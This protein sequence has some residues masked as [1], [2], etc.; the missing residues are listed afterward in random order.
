MRKLSIMIFCWVAGLMSIFA[1]INISGTVLDAD[2]GQPI[3]GAT[4]IVKNTTKG[5]ITDNNGNFVISVPSTNT[6]LRFSYI[7][8]EAIEAPAKAGMTIRLTT[9]AKELDEV[10]VTALGMTREKKSLGYSV[11]EIQGESLEKV[12]ELNVINS[13]AGREPGLIISQTAGGPTGSSRVEIRGSSMLT[14]NNQPLYVVDGVPIDNSNFGSASKDGG[15][16]LGDGISSIN[17]DDIE[18]ISVLKG[19]AASALYGS[20]AGNGVIM[21]TTKKAKSSRGS[22]GVELNSTTTVE[23]QLTKYNNVQYLYGQGTSGRISGTSDDRSNSAKSWGPRIDDGLNIWYFDNQLRP[24][25]ISNTGIDD[26]FRLGVT[27]NNT[28]TINKTKEDTGLRISYSDLRN[29]DIVP[30]SGMSRNTFSIRGNTKVGNKIDIDVKANYINENVKNRPALAGDRNNVGKNLITLPSTYDINLLK[31]NYKTDEGNYFN[32]NNDVNRVNPYWTINEMSN[33]SFKSR[34]LSTALISYAITKKLKLKATGG[35]DFSTFTFVDFAPRTT[36]GKETGYL[37]TQDNTNRTLN[38]DIQ[39]TYKTNF[40]K[41]YSVLGSVGASMLKT[42]NFQTTITGKDMSE[43]TIKTI[44]SFSEKTI[45]ESPYQRQINSAYGMVNLGYKNLV[46]LDATLRVD[47]TTT[48]INN[49]YLYPSISGSFI[50]SELFPASFKPV[51]SFAKLRGSWAE[52]GSDTSPYLMR[53]DY[54][55]YPNSINGL[56]MGGVAGSTIPNPDLKPT[57]TRSWEAGTELSFIGKRILLDLT[58]YDQ[59]SRDQI[60]RVNTSIGTGFSTAIL[61]SGVLNNKG[62]EIK[63]NTIPIQTKDLTWNLGVNFARNSNRVTALGDAQMYEIENAEWVGTAGVRVM[64]V[65]GQ[66][67]GTI[68]GKDYQR[69]ERGQIIVDG[70]TGLPTV[71]DFYTILGN[72]HWDWTGGMFTNLSYKNWTVNAILDVKVG[73]DMYSQTMRS[74]FSSG[75]AK[76]TLAGRDEWYQSEEQ[77]L[78]AGVEPKDWIPTGGY[79]VDGVVKTE[80]PDGTISWVDNTMYA[81][82]EKYWSS[83]VANNI[84]GYFT[85]DNSYLKVRELSLTYSFPRKVIS[86][87]CENLSFS[88][89]ARNPFILYSNVPNIDPDSNYNNGNGKG[90]E[91]GSLPSRKSYGVNLNVKF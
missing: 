70:T 24:Y 26:F 73:A 85:L 50:A 27:V 21:I 38:A 52:V 71:T 43:K 39:L 80:N 6:L 30:N 28:V 84:P 17:P 31:N 35:A 47:N 14:G 78:A 53:L 87:F 5:T 2:D 11:G 46:Y 8:K 76:E 22:Y 33:E 12:K 79:L 59:T 60:R 32:W 61:N 88:L 29:G 7:G 10:I 51:L 86:K 56:P 16:D 45:R 54:S 66:Q 13:L 57:R 42:D 72:S 62:V 68:I 36:P 63:L 74:T 44:N 65:V 77:R 1:Q 49:T 20:Q 48:L 18:S 19:P 81:N 75:K 89:V 9:G 34:I 3:I 40:S 58:Y 41:I 64:A 69:N 4:V 25:T 91:Y 15:F 23:Q 90:I 55:L 67:L 37:R 82:P 83:F